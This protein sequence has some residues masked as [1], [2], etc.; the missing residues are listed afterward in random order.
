MYIGGVFGDTFAQNKLLAV[1]YGGLS[2][3]IALQSIGGFFKIVSIPYYIFIF[4]GV[5]LFNSCVF[6]TMITILAQWFPKKNRGFLIGFWATCNN[7]GNILGIQIAAALLD[8]YHGS[9]PWLLA[10]IAIVLFGWSMV[11]LF[12]LKPDPAQLGFHITEETDHEALVRTMAEKLTHQEIKNSK[13]S[14]VA[15]LIEDLKATGLNKN[16]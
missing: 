8:L 12:F 5:G 14:I 3:C 6:P 9:W 4:A 13:V 16:E 10:T 7:M 1:A 2:C 15:T 11:L